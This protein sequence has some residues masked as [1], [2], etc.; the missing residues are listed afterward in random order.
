MFDSVFLNTLVLAGVV[1]G[2][3]LSFLIWKI[4]RDQPANHFLAAL[5]LL[6]SMAC[7]NLYLVHQSGY[8]SVPVLKVLSAIIPLVIIMPLG[9]LI[10]FYVRAGLDDGFVFT[11]KMRLHFYLAL[12]DIIPQLVATGYG[13][14]LLTNMVK[15]N[16]KPGDFINTY[17]VYIDILRWIS[18]TVYLCLSAQYISSMRRS[19]GAFRKIKPSYAQWLQHIVYLLLVFQSVWLV[20]LI[21]YIIPRYTELLL[22]RVDWYPLYIPLVIIIYWLGFR[23]YLSERGVAEQNKKNNTGSRLDPSII[24]SG[25][26][27]LIRAMEEEKLYL[28]PD[29][30]LA[31]MAGHT[32]VP[33]RIISFIINQEFGKSFSDFV[34]GY[35]IAAIQEKLLTAN[36]KDRTIAAIAYECGFNSQPTFQRAFKAVTGL[37]PSEFLLKNR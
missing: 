13:I 28:N 24:R 11:K 32:G 36:S 23:G 5:L 16:E 19:G 20:Y 22:N 37:T 7:L 12:F 10:Y 26:E 2:F 34:N 14:A 17:N 25:A 1:Q 30:S 8:E 3:I 18:L 33:A 15:P 4:R 21:P 9:P 35:R 6:A 29:L 27:R 31:A